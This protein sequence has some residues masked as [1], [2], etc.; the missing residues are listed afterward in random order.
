[1]TGRQQPTQLGVAAP[2]LR[3]QQQSGLILDGHLR[4]DQQLHAQSARL[5]MRP[6]NPIHAVAIE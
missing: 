4:A 3:Q 1:M 6:H 2:I 5:Y